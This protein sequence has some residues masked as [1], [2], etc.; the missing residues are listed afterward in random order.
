MARVSFSN[1]NLFEEWGQT[2]RVCSFTKVL[3]QDQRIGFLRTR[4]C[5]AVAPPSVR[6]RGS[7][8]PTAMRTFSNCGDCCEARGTFGE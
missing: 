2:M 1:M 7:C 4:S 3:Q 6:E 5:L 8:N